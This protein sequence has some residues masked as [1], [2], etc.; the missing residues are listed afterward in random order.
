MHSDTD[1]SLL[2]ADVVI[3]GVFLFL[4]LTS[5]ITRS[6]DAAP[7]A[8][9]WTVV[10]YAIYGG[11]AIQSAFKHGYGDS[12]DLTGARAMQISEAIHGIA[13]SGHIVYLSS[14]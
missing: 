5:L 1:K 6:A 14:H 12:S 2:I 13:V 10:P 4:G 3:G 11:T 7:I 8:R 9:F